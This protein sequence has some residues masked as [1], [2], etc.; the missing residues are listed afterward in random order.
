MKTRVVKWGNSQAIRLPKELLEQAN[1][2]G[3]ETVELAVHGAGLLITPARPVYTLAEL[4][5]GITP[6]N[7]H[8]E[9]NTDGAPGREEW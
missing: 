8:E 4:V 1:L 3:G 7:R 5:A 6:A 9:M 2:R